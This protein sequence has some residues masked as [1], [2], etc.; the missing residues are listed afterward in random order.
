[1]KQAQDLKQM[2]HQLDGQKY[3]AYKRLKG[4]YQF[5]QFRLV[6]DHI[7]AD[8]F[9]SPSK[10]RLI[11][12]R[13]VAGF[14]EHLLD[15]KAKRIAVADFLTRA[16]EQVI[17][18][19]NH[20]NSHDRKAGQ[21]F[22][23][24]CGQE[25]LTRTSVVFDDSH[26]E[27]RLEVG[28]PAAGRKILGK[29]AVKT[30][31][32]MLPAVVKK[33]LIYQQLDQDA[34]AQQVILMKDQQYI[35]QQLEKNHWIAFVANGAVL[36]RRSGVSDHP[37]SDAVPFESPARFEVTLTLPSSQTVTGMAIPEGITLIV[38]GGYHGK[39]TL[40][41]ALERGVYNHILND[42]REFV[43]TR[44]DAMKIRAEDG[45]SIEKVNI[46]PFIDNLPAH[47][48]TTEFSTENASGST[49]QAANVMEALE[50]QAQLLLIDEDTSAT[51]F[52][53]RDSRMQRLIA[54]EK[55]P[56]TPFSH[57]VKALYEDYQVSTILIVGGSGDYFEVADQVLMMDEY[58]LKDVTEEAKDI[59]A[60]DALSQQQTH[61]AHFGDLPQR[62]ALPSTFNHKGKAHRFKAKGLHQIIYGKDPIDISGL[63]QLVDLS[64]VRAIAAMLS[65]FHHEIM[66]QQQPMSEAVD[67]LYHYIETH[68]LSAVVPHLGHPGNLAL[69]RKQE[70]I[71]TL[72]RYRQL[73]VKS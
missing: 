61:E 23:D 16:V 33:G 34:L 63:E 26:I 58:H 38:G 73:K 2:L 68:G 65:Y 52:M 30:L 4:Q 28:M 37:M 31:I 15:D 22:I 11:I 51:N 48:D 10:M 32:D 1:M 56:I 60:S 66:N 13:D 25:M 5:E 9:A 62:V 35:R 40:L 41:E 29:P 14:P 67:E 69:P 59:A 6:V 42:G 12:D 43:W 3:G 55:E 8:P 49:S 17:H 19:V 64:Q 71:G 53:I 18:D 24:H 70:F 20:Q 46:S 50:A 27:V 21:I 36:P 47:K 45:R 39:S 54:P 44:H 7:Q 72:N 57:K